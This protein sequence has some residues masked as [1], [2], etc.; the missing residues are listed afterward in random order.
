[1]VQVLQSH[2]IQA[3]NRLTPE[4]IRKLVKNIA[5]NTFIML[6]FVI[7]GLF[8]TLQLK[9]PLGLSITPTLPSYMARSIHTAIS[10]FVVNEALFFY[11][12]WLFHANKWL[13]KSTFT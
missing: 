11:G 12:H 13:Y 4:K 9:T 8:L 2:R 3:R 5:I 7:G 6:P 1:M 10:I